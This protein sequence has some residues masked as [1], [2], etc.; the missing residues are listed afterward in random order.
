[1]WIRLGYGPLAVERSRRPRGGHTHN[2][3]C[4]TLG[5]GGR[6]ERKWQEGQDEFERGDSSACAAVASSSLQ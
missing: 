2:T 1:M 5:H 3:C 6:K 4:T